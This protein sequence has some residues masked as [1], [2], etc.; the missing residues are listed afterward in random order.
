MS[1]FCIILCEIK[2]ST[3]LNSCVA[4]SHHKLFS[5]GGMELKQESQIAVRKIMKIQILMFR[6]PWI[7]R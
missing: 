4:G 2:S 7:I 3:L 1:P 6:P 5:Y